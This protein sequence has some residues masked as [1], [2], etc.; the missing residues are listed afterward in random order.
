LGELGKHGDEQFEQPE[1]QLGGPICVGNSGVLNLAMPIKIA[2][3][4]GERFVAYYRVSTQ[5]Q[6]ASGLGLDAQ[7]NSI[8]QFTA[9]CGGEVVAEFT[10]TE[11]GKKAHNRPALQ[12]ALALAK[13]RGAVLLIAKLDRLARNV[14][15]ISGLMESSVRFVAVDMP[16]KDRLMLHVQAAFAEEEARRISQ[17][18]KEALA[19]AKRRGV[20]VGATGRVLAARYKAAATERAQKD[21]LRVFEEAKEAGCRTTRAFRD[22]LNER[23]VPSPGGGRWHLPNTFKTLKRLDLLAAA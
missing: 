7:R 22:F 3:T 12:E 23:N 21:F 14:F 16:T 11:S 13:S 5:K 17:R 18:T 15:F 2:Q 4:N 1:L 19:A 20:D 10:E 6:G 9:A 8:Q